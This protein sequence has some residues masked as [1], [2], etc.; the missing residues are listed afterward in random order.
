MDEVFPEEGARS[1]SNVGGG[2]ITRSKTN[3]GAKSGPKS[4]IGEMIGKDW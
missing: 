2:S 4:K 3:S 1:E